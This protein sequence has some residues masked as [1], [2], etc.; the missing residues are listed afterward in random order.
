MNAEMQDTIVTPTKHS[1]DN[2]KGVSQ[3]EENGSTPPV[4][5]GRAVSKTEYLLHFLYKYLTKRDKLFY[6]SIQEVWTLKLDG[7]SCYN[8]IWVFAIAEVVSVHTSHCIVGTHN[9]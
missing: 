7:I 6:D 1:R 9:F 5:D 8:L 2:G 3:R 4:L